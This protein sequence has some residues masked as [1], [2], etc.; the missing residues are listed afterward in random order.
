MPFSVPLDFIIMQKNRSKHSFFK[1]R[2]VLLLFYTRLKR[3]FFSR[4]KI[5]SLSG[6]GFR[7]QLVKPERKFEKKSCERFKNQENAKKFE[8]F[9]KIF[10]AAAGRQS[11]FKS[12]PIGESRQTR[13]GP[14]FSPPT[15]FQGWKWKKSHKIGIF[16]G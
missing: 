2:A 15:S 14:D 6:S 3:E 10:F 1:C 5:K 9:E 16:G 7:I 8:K 13:S 11:N 4:V 12:F